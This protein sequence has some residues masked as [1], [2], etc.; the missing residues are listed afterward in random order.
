MDI[1]QKVIN[2]EEK[3]IK[4]FVEERIEFLN[5]HAVQVS[6][7][8]YLSPLKFSDAF[9]GFIPLNTRIKYSCINAEDY[10]M[11]TTDFIYDC[12]NFIRKY[13]I[14]NKG[15]LIYNLFPF[16]ITYFGG[17][18]INDR[19]DIFYD[20]SLINNP[21]VNVFEHFKNNKLGDLKGKGAALC[22]EIGA[23]VQQ[24]LSF[25]GYETYYCMGVIE[26]DGKREIHCFNIVD[27]KNG[28][29]II[30]YGA[31]IPKYNK[32]SSIK[33]YN[34]FVGDLTE[35][36]LNDFINKNIAKTFDDY[37]LKDGEKILTG[38]TRTYVVGCPKIKKDSIISKR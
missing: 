16:I 34:V 17:I 36:E 24:I 26:Y 21:G 33:R 14:N 30:D 29:C 12:V 31:A 19:E 3:D 7:L 37:Y 4:S 20:S 11:E 2:C 27:S 35:E 9:K 8:G 15:L 28:Y 25:F 1:L 23:L 13:N 10:G 22:T 38:Q 32:D 18:G 6:S 5:S